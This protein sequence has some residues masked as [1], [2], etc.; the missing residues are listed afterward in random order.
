MGVKMFP[1]EIEVEGLG[2]LVPCDKYTKYADLKNAT[3]SGMEFYVATYWTKQFITKF[4]YGETFS[5]KAPKKG[6]PYDLDILQPIAFGDKVER[7]FCLSVY[8]D[9]LGRIEG[10]DLAYT[11]DPKHGK[12]RMSNNC[13]FELYVPKVKT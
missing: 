3:E 10:C 1:N 7:F 11:N 2:V 4:K 13:E 12:V 6:F 5:V 9:A 8:T